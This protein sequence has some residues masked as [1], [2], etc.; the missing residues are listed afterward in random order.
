MSCLPGPHELPQDLRWRSVYRGGIMSVILFLLR[1]FFAISFSSHFL[2]L[3]LSLLS[4]HRAARHSANLSVLFFL[5]L[6][7][8]CLVPFLVFFLGVLLLCRISFRSAFPLLPIHVRLFSDSGRARS[9]SFGC[10]VSRKPYVHS[11]HF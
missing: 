2:R 10:D 6:A 3:A 5:L 8:V 7:F 1:F 11:R 9:I 4:I